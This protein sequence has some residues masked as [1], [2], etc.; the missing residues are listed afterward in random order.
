VLA[1]PQGKLE[2]RTVD[3]YYKPDT[4]QALPVDYFHGIVMVGKS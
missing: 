4:M 3:Q 1:N 2:D